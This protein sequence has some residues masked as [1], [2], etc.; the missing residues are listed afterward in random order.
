MC[1]VSLT[2]GST[3]SGTRAVR[4]WYSRAGATCGDMST[5]DAAARA[6]APTACASG[7]GPQLRTPRSRAGHTYGL[8]GAVLGV[9][10]VSDTAKS[11]LVGHL[12]T[13][14][15]GVALSLVLIPVY[16]MEA[17]HT[18]GSTLLDA[19]NYAAFMPIT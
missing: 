12:D 1:A 6:P 15:E 10:P 3:S 8:D 17:S 9:Q 11:I 19:H 16:D 4:R 5:L 18:K 13:T 7:T 14:M 2:L